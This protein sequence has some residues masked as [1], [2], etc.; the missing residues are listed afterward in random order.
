MSV[1][2]EMKKYIGV[3][4]LVSARKRGMAEKANQQKRTLLF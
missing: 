4:M 1:L 2:A 3:K